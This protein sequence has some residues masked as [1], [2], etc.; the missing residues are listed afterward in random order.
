MLLFFE[1][2]QTK[3]FLL[4]NQKTGYDGYA[5]RLNHLRLKFTYNPEFIITIYINKPKS[6]RITLDRRYWK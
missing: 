5:I 2:Q 1:W 4:V 6:N 3:L